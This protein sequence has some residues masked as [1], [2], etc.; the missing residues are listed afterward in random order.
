M[1]TKPSDVKGMRMK[2]MLLRTARQQKGWNQQQLADFAGV[3]LSTIERAERGE[4]IRVDNLQR[5]CTC[6]QKTPEQLGLLNTEDREVNRRQANKTIA[7]LVSAL[8]ITS[9]NGWIE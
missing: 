2:N 3:S 4:P 5:L 1:R 8:L 6:L 7:G 9:Y